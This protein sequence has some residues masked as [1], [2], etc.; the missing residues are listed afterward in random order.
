MATAQ[1][2]GLTV[3][4]TGASGYIA[5]R[6]I[7]A[8]LADDRVER[9]LGFDVSP[10][11]KRRTHDRYVFD[12]ID[13]RNEHLAARL[14]G[15]DVLIHLAFVMDP[16]KD[17][18]EMRD[19]NVNGTQNVMRAAGK[20]GVKKVIYTSSATVYGAHPD[21]DFPL[22][23]DSPLRA[24]L[25][26]SYPAHKLETEYVVREVREEFPD[27]K[28]ITYRPAIVF[29]PNVDNA[30]SH[31]LELP[32][33]VSVQ[34]FSPPM[35]F[36]H[37]D[38]VGDALVF[39]V[40]ED[41][42]GPYNLA[43]EGW[44]DWHEL[45]SIVGKRQTSLPEPIAFQLSERLWNL[46]LAEAPAGMLHY[47]MHPWVMSVDKLSEAGFTAKRS[48]RETFATTVERTSTKVRFGRA[49]VDKGQLKLGALAGAGLL[50]G[51]VVWR[52][53]KRASA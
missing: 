36:V 43:P 2:T 7:D 52:G 3:A 44:L 20:S 8:L 30:W 4:V 40:F 21:N 31:F 41:L 12:R 25:D 5:G 35:Q 39:A 38:D 16:I 53:A 32:T 23:E 50:A 15:V 37:E 28:V 34:G 18:G 45:V 17:E 19:I 13:V 14:K 48:N 24:N 46:G 10:E 1:K 22:T 27:L 29:G 9:V 26:F 6:A 49:R 51:L 33:L 47:V 11:R 42:D